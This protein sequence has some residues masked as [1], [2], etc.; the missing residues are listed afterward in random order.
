MVESLKLC[1]SAF[2][3]SGE[4]CAMSPQKS[5]AGCSGFSAVTICC[6]KVEIDRREPAR[7]DVGLGLADAEVDGLVRADVQERA[8]I[9]GGKLGE[10]LLDQRERTGLAGR[11][12]GAVRRLGERLVLLP[13]ERVAQMP[14]GLLLRHD[15]DVVRARVGDEGPHPLR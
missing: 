10:L 6:M 15:G 1:G 7:V 12:H 9:L 13:G 5:S 11:E 8:G 2:S 14:E 4:S 3:R